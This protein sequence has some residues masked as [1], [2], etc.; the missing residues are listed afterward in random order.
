MCTFFK[1]D[2]VIVA[3][4]SKNSQA[5]QLDQLRKSQDAQPQVLSMSQ[6][7]RGKSQVNTSKSQVPR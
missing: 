7:F 4:L 3:K 2:H 1:I 5:S 6:V